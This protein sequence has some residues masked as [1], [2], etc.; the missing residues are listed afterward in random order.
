MKNRGK[1]RNYN[2]AG[3]RTNFER[4]RFLREHIPAIEFVK[5]I[6][7]VT[8][9]FTRL[10]N[11]NAAELDNR[12]RGRTSYSIQEILI[13][14]LL[15]TCLGIAVI[16]DLQNASICPALID[17]I[18][19]LT[20]QGPSRIP[21]YMTINNALS[22][23]TSLSWLEA[24]SQDIF[25]KLHRSGRY[26]RQERDTSEKK[27]KLPGVRVILDGTDFAFFRKP[28]CPF[29]L[30]ATFKKGTP[31]EKKFYFHKALIAYAVLAPKFLVPIAIE[32]IKNRE[33]ERTSKQDCENAAAL[34]A[35]DRIKKRFPKMHFIMCGDALYANRTFIRKCK[36][37]HWSYMF[38]LKKGVQPTLCQ[39]FQALKESGLIPSAEV[40]FE[41]E[42]GTLYWVEDMG[43]IIE[44]DLDIHIL[45]YTTSMTVREGKGKR[46]TSGVT[47]RNKDIKMDMPEL[48]SDHDKYDLNEKQS[49]KKS[50]KARKKAMKEETAS[51]KVKA[52]VEKINSD[53]ADDL[54]D[55]AVHASSEKLQAGDAIR[56]TFMYIT[57][58]RPTEENVCDLLIH[59][60]DRWTIE[61]NFRNAKL[62]PLQIE[63][64]RSMDE[65]AMEVYFWIEQIA[66]LLVHLYIYHSGILEVAG[67]QKEVFAFLR[68]SFEN[69]CLTDHKEYLSD[70]TRV[71]LRNRD[72]EHHRY[73]S[74]EIIKINI[75]PPEK[76]EPEKADCHR[77]ATKGR[78]E[79]SKGGNSAAKEKGK[80]SCKTKSG[81]K[82]DKA[83][84]KIE[85][86]EEN[87]SDPIRDEKSG[88]AC[89]F[90]PD[91]EMQEDSP[92]LFDPVQSAGD[93]SAEAAEK[94]KKEK[95]VLEKT[96]TAGR[97]NK[98]ASRTD[99]GP[100]MQ[101]RT[102]LAGLDVGGSPFEGEDAAKKDRAQR[103]PA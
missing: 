26:T 34:R 29:D 6:E 42:E 46:R 15:A 41:N 79:T 19:F 35:M 72:P 9:L 74:A 102:A 86:R 54:R 85:N 94:A 71:C 70:M 7:C 83:S 88:E 22:K 56:L 30:T 58:I 100:R 92:N 39:D 59:M 50:A 87:R 28:H 18:A 27:W 62:G 81:E 65:N 24:L 3:D 11:V 95:P 75:N 66:A 78:G 76:E 8:G 51:E 36:E 16:H 90:T 68:S 91:K 89:G 31:E 47:L 82:P 53:Q 67:S 77:K 80:A 17:N 69:Q 14:C 52:S 61:E 4:T 55:A 57:N 23:I 1:V 73:P 98:C 60:R 21:N 84:E 43:Q 101:R 38:T 49:D 96:Y 37:F 40:R 97:R 48:S 25:E 12:S 13:V 32:F 2:Q 5:I 20:G 44:S 45:E 10:R 63:H 33:G 93:T 103:I 99:P 64:L